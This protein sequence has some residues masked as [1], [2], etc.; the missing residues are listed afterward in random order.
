MIAARTPP[1]RT[2]TTGDRDL[3][4][5]VAK[6]TAAA[7]AVGAVAFGVWQVRL[8]GSI[9]VLAVGLPQL[10]HV[11]VLSLLWL[12]VIREFQS[13]VV[14]PTSGGRS[15]CRRSSRSSRSLSWEC[16]SADWRL[17]SQSPSPRR[18]QRS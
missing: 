14:N 7:L 15:G 10:L 3:T 1:E 17:S 12:V 9:L 16:C 6:A 13:Y 5:R 11:A 18:S 4:V 8:I 2:D